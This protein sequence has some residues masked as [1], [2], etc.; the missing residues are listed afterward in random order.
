MQERANR[1]GYVQTCPGRRSAVAAYVW[2]TI[3]TMAMS[4][5]FV[6]SGQ[7]HSDCQSEVCVR[8]DAPPTRS[9]MVV[10]NGALQERLE[11][12]VSLPSP[13]SATVRVQLFL[14]SETVEKGAQHVTIRTLIMGQDKIRYVPELQDLNQ[15]PKDGRKQ[16]SFRLGVG[17]EPANAPTSTS[18][19]FSI[20]WKGESS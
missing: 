6:P 7:G 3:L 18:R 20:E 9:V 11:F 8:I 4:A 14:V 10:E 16:S 5:I 1:Q 13:P 2:W 19:K 15:W 17:K 12:L